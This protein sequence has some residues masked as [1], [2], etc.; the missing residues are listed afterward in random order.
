ML[1]YPAKF[2]PDRKAGGYVVTFPD[3]PDGVTEG[4]T[5]HEALD[6]ARDCLVTLFA[7]YM[8]EGQPIPEASPLPARGHRLVRLPFAVGL[9]I[10]LYNAWLKSGVRKADLARRL[11]IPRANVER[12]FNLR[13]ASRPELI[14][15]A[16]RALGKEVDLLVRDV[17]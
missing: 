15:D 1:S 8:R 6:M 11:G 9:K 7:V 16:F 12:L 2:T 10:E 4:D 17:A 14:E 3:V 13:H 5:V